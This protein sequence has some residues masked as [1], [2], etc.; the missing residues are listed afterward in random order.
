MAGEQRVSP[1]D[2]IRHI[3]EDGEDYWSAR[4]LAK[5]LTYANWQNFAKVIQQA[6]AACATSGFVPSDHFIETDKVIEAGKGA[7]RRIADFH[8]SRYACYLIVMNG[9]PEKPVIA[10]GQTYFA[11]RTREAELAEELAGLSE[12]DKRMITRRQLAEKNKQTA[13][14]VYSAGVITARD[15]AVFQDHGYRG[16]YNGETARDI[17]RRKG[18]AKGEK[19]LDWMG[20]TE[21]AAN[22]FRTTQAEEKI[23]REGIDTKEE[24]NRAHYVAG[25]IVRRVIIEDFGGTPPELLPTPTESIQQIEAREQRRLERERQPSLFPELGMIESEREG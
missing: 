2:A 24:A 17:T 3:A 23:R 20:S 7:Q 21:L 1:F 16:L 9:D 11:V 13:A 12:A 8:L 14:T 22:L 19:I 6:Q 18:L 4:E 15:F 25:Q 5:I 10:A